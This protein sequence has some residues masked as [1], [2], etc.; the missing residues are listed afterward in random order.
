VAELERRLDQDSAD[1]GMPTSK[2]SIGARERR[3][4]RRRQRQESERDRRKDRK[5]GGQPGHP[6][7]GLSRDPDP[8]E[9]KPAEPC[10]VP[11]VQGA[12]GRRSD[13]GLAVGAGL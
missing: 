13:R 9:T 10:G 7:M 4:A 11:T 1:S 12:A 2:E 5:P 6:G 8:D 3:K